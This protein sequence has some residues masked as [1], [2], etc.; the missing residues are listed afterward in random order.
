MYGKRVVLAEYFTTEEL[1]LLFIVRADFEE[2]EVVEIKTPL[3][4]IRQ[5]VTKSFG[6]AEGSSKV[7]DLNLDELQARFGPFIEPIL[8][9]TDEGDIVWLVP[10][11]ALH[12][13]PLHAIKVEG[14]YL[15]ERNP[16]CYTPSASVMKYCHAK[17]KPEEQR[18][19]QALVLGDPDG[20]LPNSRS[21]AF[22]VS[23][24]LGIEPHIGPNAQKAQVVQA[25]KDENQRQAID[26]LHFAC[27]GRFD[28]FQPL[29]SGLQ[30]ADDTLTAE[31]IFGLEMR[32]DLVTLSACE[33]GVS[34][35]R[36]GD[37]LI[38]LMRALIYA[39]TPSVVL[40]LWEVDDVSTELLMTRFYELRAQGMNKAE[41]LQ[42]AQRFVRDLTAADVLTHYENVSAH[43]A[44]GSD[45][46]RIRLVHQGQRSVYRALLRAEHELGDR[47]DLDYHLFAHPYYWAP[48]VLVGD[49]K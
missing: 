33:S 26:I 38:G 10:H 11:D 30:L 28:P 32:A 39:G 45:A 19:G 1:T 25:L 35:R 3:D 44:P 36:P 24:V 31:E 37:E 14:R 49:W 13:L 43:L 8:P 42:Q 40:S 27:H 4:E 18:G 2:P 48:F 6:V 20:T 15:V 23:E 22:A 46:E 47:P 12:Y 16:V 9:W 21:E 34:E 29:R 41:S 7:R 5:F 17:R